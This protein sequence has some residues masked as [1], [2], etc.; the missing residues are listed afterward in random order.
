MLY[1]EFTLSMEITWFLRGHLHAFDY[2]GG[3]PREVL[4]DNL[5]TAVLDRA[6][7]GTIHWHPRY[8][9]FA[10]YYGFTPRACRPYRAQTKGKVERVIGY[11]RGNF[12]PGVHAEGLADLNAQA[13]YNGMTPL[14]LAVDIDMD[15]VSQASD[16]EQEFRDKLT[17]ST[18]RLLLSLGADYLFGTLERRLT[19]PGLRAA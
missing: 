14:H 8:L 7:D 11:V 18:T 16:T 5:K 19:P 15:S 1:L 2:F 6:A 9:D 13:T 4:H 17:F 3:A 12:W 10:N